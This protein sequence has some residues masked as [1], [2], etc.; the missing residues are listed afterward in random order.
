MDKGARLSAVDYLDRFFE[1]IRLEARANPDFAA[2][3]TRALGGEVVF[4]KSDIVEVANPMEIAANQGEPGLR[5]TFAGLDAAGLRKT[6]RTANLA[7]PVD[8]RGKDTTELTD[9]L[10]RRA[11]AK[12]AERRRA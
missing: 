12:L 4:A 8:M 11:L 5:E 10:V 6:M 7:T 1:E 3:L 2:R 9:M